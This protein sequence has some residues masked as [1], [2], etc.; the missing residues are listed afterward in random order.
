MDILEIS[1]LQVKTRIGVH[2]W[3]QQIHQ[4]LLIDITLPLDCR[5]CND[6]LE[7]TLDYDTLC[8][9]VTDFVENQSF[10]LIET[11]AGKVAALI[12]ENYPVEEV[13]VAVSKP[14]AVKNA[15]NIKISI[16]R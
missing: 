14:Q 8:K 16:R 2:A 7:K 3:E 12:K 15:G 10:Q 6:E 1:A 5:A 11:V 4:T 13:T 9:S